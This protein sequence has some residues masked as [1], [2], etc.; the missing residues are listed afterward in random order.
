MI[1]IDLKLLEI[2]DLL[3]EDELVKT[4]HQTERQVTEDKNLL[5]L[6]KQYNEYCDQYE[7][8]EYD[9][10]RVELLNKTEALKKEIESNDLYH[11]YLSQQ[12]TIDDMVL[13]LSKLVFKDLLEIGE[14]CGCKQR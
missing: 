3:Q 1:E 11:D 8:I 14:L 9:A 12:V 6:I 10:Y 2:S 7:K 5:D 13:D 4:Y